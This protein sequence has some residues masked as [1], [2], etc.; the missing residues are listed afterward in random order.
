MRQTKRPALLGAVLTTSLLASTAFGALTKPEIERG[1]NAKSES[2]LACY[3][4][5]VDRNPKLPTGRV[6]VKFSIETDGKVSQ[7]KVVRN[8]LRDA[9]LA[10]CMQGVF[11]KLDYGRIDERMVVEYPLDLEP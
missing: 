2:L 6:V 5:A 8:D 7:A 10:R 1:V 9:E 3:D 11:M 4:A